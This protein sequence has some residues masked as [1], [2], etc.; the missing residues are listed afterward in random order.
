VA[1]ERTAARV[2][3]RAKA[4]KAV[5]KPN[6]E[7][8][9][10]T[11]ERCCRC[12]TILTS[13]DKYHYSISCE[14]CECDIEWESHERDNPIKSAYWRWRAICFCVRF[15][16]YGAARVSGVLLHKLRNKPDA[17]HQLFDERREP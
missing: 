8:K 14:A 4:I 12:H 6:V 5:S 3:G 16:F 9:M 13:E 15:L 1:G 2:P 17:G 10:T 7:L 11:K